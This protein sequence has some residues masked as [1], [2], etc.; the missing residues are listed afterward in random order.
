MVVFQGGSQPQQQ[1][2]A[3]SGGSDNTVGLLVNALK[4]SEG[5]VGHTYS[6]SLGNATI[7]YG[8]ASPSALARGTISEPDAAQLLQ[9]RAVNDYLKPAL[10]SLPSEVVAQMTPGMKAAVGSLAYN[11]GQGGFES[12]RVYSNLRQGDLQGAGNAISTTMTE[13]GLLTSRRES[14]QRLFFSG[15][16]D[17]EFQSNPGT[18]MSDKN[19]QNMLDSADSQS[20]AAS[21]AF[22]QSQQAR[23][24]AIN[25]ESAIK[26][27]Q[28][29][30]RATRVL[31]TG[32]EQVDDSV[33]QEKRRQ[34]DLAA[35]NLPDTSTNRYQTSV[36]Q[37][38]RQEEDANKTNNRS[39]R[40]L[41]DSLN[42]LQAYRDSVTEIGKID[43]RILAVLPELD[44]Q[45]INLTG[46][47]DELKAAIASTAAGFAGARA[48]LEE[49][50]AREVASNQLNVSIEQNSQQGQYET[51]YS[52][53]LNR[54]GQGAT[55]IEKNL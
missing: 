12:T 2:Q 28:Q 13:D 34:E 43:P 36:R 29:L 11:M 26:V 47:S 54:N 4:Q 35:A 10:A 21:A 52:R 32:G 31:Q 44:K 9:Q 46:R 23:I 20:S 37:I 5:F 33:L 48:K 50:R 53:Y 25:E 24:A 15:N 7:G 22:I 19:S 41:T 42:D 16:G 49:D 6:D 55:A 18:G 38:D 39:L 3:S 17:G 14:E 27:Q 45:I 51:E 40:S 1:R 8:D 30:N